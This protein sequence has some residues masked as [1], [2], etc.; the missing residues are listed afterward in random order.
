MSIPSMHKN[1]GSI[2]RDER[3]PISPGLQVLVGN[4]TVGQ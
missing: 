4:T 1:L 3:V 2:P